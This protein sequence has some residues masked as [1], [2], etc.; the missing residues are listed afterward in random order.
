MDLGK[1][2]Y[3]RPV[4]LLILLIT[5]MLIATASA[6]VYYSLIM[7]TGATITEPAVAFKKGADWDSSWSMGKNGTWC[8]LAL[9]AYPNATL[10]YDEPLNLTNTGTAVNITLRAVSISPSSGPSVGNFTFINF[11]LHDESG[12]I[13]GSLNFTTSGDAWNS[14]SISSTEM[15][16]ADEWYIAIQ[17]RAAPEARKDILANIVIAVDV[18]E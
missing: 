4:K 14:P 10:T 7:Q 6:A 8:R 17:T 3:K 15:D 2:R 16:A 1:T 12:V 13:K 5:S 9:R 11:T 18:E